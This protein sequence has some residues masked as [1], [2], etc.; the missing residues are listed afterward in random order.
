MVGALT[1]LSLYI[2]K[3]LF[4][5]NASKRKAFCVFVKIYFAQHRAAFAK[6]ILTARA[7]LTA[8]LKVPGQTCR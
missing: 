5:I 2:C 4:S 7:L 1:R 8:Q 6:Q 3:T